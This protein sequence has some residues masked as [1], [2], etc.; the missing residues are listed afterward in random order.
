M[1][2]LWNFY[3]KHSLA[4]LLV[5]TT[6]V[7]IITG[8]LFGI[9]MTV[10]LPFSII[11]AVAL[12]RNQW[13]YHHRTKVLYMSPSTHRRLPSCLYMMGTFWVWDFGTYL[14]SAYATWADISNPKDGKKQ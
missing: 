8:M 7:G 12:V 11:M 9:P 3:E 13:V 1:K 4:I 2:L 10:L 6:L 5:C 14:S